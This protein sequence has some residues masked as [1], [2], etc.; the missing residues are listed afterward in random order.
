MLETEIIKKYQENTLSMISGGLDTLTYPVKSPLGFVSTVTGI[1]TFI[2]LRKLKNVQTATRSLGWFAGISGVAASY[3]LL[4]DVAH[5]GK[6]KNSEERKETYKNIGSSLAIIGLAFIG[7]RGRYILKVWDSIREYSPSVAYGNKLKSLLPEDLQD[8]IGREV[9]Y[10]KVPELLREE[11]TKHALG[12]VGIRKVNEPSHD[13][14]LHVVVQFLTGKE[15]FSELQDL[16]KTE[17]IL[18]KLDFL[19][20]ENDARAILISW[21]GMGLSKIRTFHTKATLEIGESKQ[22]VESIKNGANIL[23][24]AGNCFPTARQIYRILRTDSFSLTNT[25]ILH[26]GTENQ[27]VPFVMQK[28][29]P[30]WRKK[31]IASILIDSQEPT[32][33]KTG[34][35]KSIFHNDHYH[36]IT[37]ALKDNPNFSLLLTD[38]SL[39]ELNVWIKEYE[40]AGGRRIVVIE[41][42]RLKSKSMMTSIN[43]ILHNGLTHGAWKPTTPIHSDDQHLD[44]GN[45]VHIFLKKGQKTLYNDS[46]RKLFGGE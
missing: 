37:D 30:F 41:G 11:L 24:I 26:V 45:L 25:P 8:K 39:P 12:A 32:K 16:V 17:V 14:L 38:P 33:M 9:S 23:S 2:G 3:Y 36:S 46:F 15:K 13:Y 29:V 1:A 10:I 21:L 5:L 19:L 27:L 22:I 28:Y 18:N 40:K 6:E 4:K 20:D 35:G 31:S 34:M 7:F 42:T 43:E 44:K